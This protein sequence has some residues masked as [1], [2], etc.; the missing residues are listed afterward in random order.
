MRNKIL[1]W[2]VVLLPLL[3]I[4]AVV[5]KYYYDEAT[6]RNVIWSE[7]VQ[8]HQP[9]DVDGIS[10]E[11]IDPIPTQYSDTAVYIQITNDSDYHVQ[12]I[13]GHIEK[14]VGDKWMV[15][16]YKKPLET[17]GDFKNKIKG[18]F[19]AAHTTDSD[20]IPFGDASR[21][22]FLPE[23]EPGEYRVIWEGYAR[24]TDSSDHVSEGALIATF[25]LE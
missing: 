9:L 6:A 13:Y 20:D 12:G 15:W 8:Q 7:C 22:G 11:I 21:S 1:I 19:V 18:L 23:R 5:G 2:L 14:R 4:G 25:T 17:T 10:I 3:G 24:P 16:G